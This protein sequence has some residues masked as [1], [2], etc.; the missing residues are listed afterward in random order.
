[1]KVEVERHTCDFV[2]ELPIKSRR[3][4]LTYLRRLEDPPHIPEIKRLDSDV[5]RMHFAKTYTIF[6]GVLVEQDLV[7]VTDMYPIGIAHKRYNRV[8]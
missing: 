4:I 7:R 3:I 1:M 6:F 5:Y 8:T 2:K